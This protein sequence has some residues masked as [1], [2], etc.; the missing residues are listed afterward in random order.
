MNRLNKNSLES[1]EYL[2][3]LCEKEIISW[4]IDF[5][6]YQVSK[7]EL[8]QTFKYWF[9]N[10]TW[11]SCNDS[12]IQFGKDASGSM[13]LLW[14][15]PKLK[16]EPPVVFMDSEGEAYL[17]SSCITD[18]IKQLA[19]GYLFFNNSWIELSLKEKKELNWEL[20]KEEVNEHFGVTNINPQEL[21]Q[22]AKLNH[23]NF[24]DWVKSKI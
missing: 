14:F 21:T 11:S 10:E 6:F 2:K 13:F 1:L 7:E 5:E 22:I 12:F 18:F 9:G 3:K 19:S 23:P 4:P 24:S 8:N 20:L 16:T 17:V 15:Y